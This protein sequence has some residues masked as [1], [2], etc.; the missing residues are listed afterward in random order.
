MLSDLTELATDSEDVA[1]TMKSM[2][3]A[4]PT[5]KFHR[6][7]AD[8]GGIH[9]VKL[10]EYKRNDEIIRLTKEYLRDMEVRSQLEHTAHQLAETY[11]SRV[12][13]GH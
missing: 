3:S 11:K 7:S 1:K 10:Y 5:L 8:K 6:F 9:L 2:E 4:G 13:E 12:R